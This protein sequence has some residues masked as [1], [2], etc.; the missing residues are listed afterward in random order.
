MVLATLTT[1]VMGLVWKTRIEMEL[2]N[3]Q[4][5]QLQA[6]YLALGGVE[7]SLTYVANVL[8]SSAPD[9]PLMIPGFVRS[10]QE[11]NLLTVFSD[12]IEIAAR[13][14]CYS[15]RD[16]QGGLNINK[17]RDDIIERALNRELTCQILDW[18]DSDDAPLGSEGVESQ[19]YMELQP[20]YVAK[21]ADFEHIRECLFLPGV[22]FESYIGEDL[23]G[24][25]GL[26]DNESDGDVSWPVDNQDYTLDLGLIDLVTIHGNGKININ[27]APLIILA[28]MPGMNHYAAQCI[29]SYRQGRDGL[30]G[31]DDDNLLV[32]NRDLSDVVGLTG[33]QKSLL[34]QHGCF[35]SQYLRVQ[36][37]ADVSQIARCGF[38]GTI[39]LSDNIPQ[40]V[41]LERVY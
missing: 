30:E 10:A 9:D 15:I 26:D 33:V 19:D 6:H 17:T 16:E 29:V 40:L 1:L 25:R 32:S 5:K 41:Y 2:V 31:T 8:A 34:E 39:E 4:A 11:E 14:L 35:T 23:N 13:S 3:H 21:N 24:N 28:S 37:Y 12:S 7:R 27:A 22:S 20:G 38:V 36:A 18:R